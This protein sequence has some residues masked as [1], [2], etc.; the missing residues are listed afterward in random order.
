MP[1]SR[2]IRNT[3]DGFPN[4]SGNIA[5]SANY[6]NEYR[7]ILV[8][9]NTVYGLGLTNANLGWAAMARHGDNTYVTP[10]PYVNIGNLQN[11]PSQ[12]GTLNAPP[13]S[14][15]STGFFEVGQW[16]QSFQNTGIRHLAHQA[17][18]MKGINDNYNSAGTIDITGGT[19][20]DPVVEQTGTYVTANI[21]FSNFRGFKKEGDG[22][23][24]D[25]GD[26]VDEHLYSTGHIQIGTHSTIS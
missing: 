18:F 23:N 17:Q 21:K 2:S 15:P 24:W 20:L 6:V 16:A 22:G 10:L 3:L 26:G 19:D 5:W 7:D 14:N 4:G 1:N 11:Y 9:F 8:F 13:S 12:S 25:N